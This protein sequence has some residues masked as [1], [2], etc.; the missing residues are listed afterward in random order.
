MEQLGS[1]GLLRDTWGRQE[2][3][4]AVGVTVA[5]TKMEVRHHLLQRGDPEGGSVTCGGETSA[6]WIT[7]A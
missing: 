2:G 1:L 3:T 4:G 5:S 6:C 7:P